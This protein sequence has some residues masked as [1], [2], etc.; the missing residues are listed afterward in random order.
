MRVLFVRHA[1]AIESSDFEG[2]DLERPL[3][4]KGRR[5]MKVIARSLA[6]RFDQPDRIICSQAERARASAEMLSSAFGGHAVEER[7]DLNPGAR[8]SS[9]HRL[10]AELWKKEDVLVV[11]VGHEPD[12]STA[13]SDLV[14]GGQLH[15]KLKK[16]G[17]ADVE[18]TGPASGRLRALLD[19]ALIIG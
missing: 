3:T 9:F 1:E 16:A 7:S 17:C 12:L 19:P 13:V 8:L 2:S 6:Q 10:L 4:G 15:L 18:M 11:L 14:A 5:T